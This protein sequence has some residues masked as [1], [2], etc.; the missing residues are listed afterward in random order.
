[1]RVPAFLADWYLAL[2]SFVV[3]ACAGIDSAR[4]PSAAITIA[5]AIKVLFFMGRFS[6][7]ESVDSR[8]FKKWARVML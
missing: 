7:A 2:H 3:S 4:L 8:A 6:Y 1:L 5:D